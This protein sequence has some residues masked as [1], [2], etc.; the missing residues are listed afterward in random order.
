MDVAD[1]QKRGPV[2]HCLH[3]RLHQHDV[4]HRGFVNH[5]QITVERV[6]VAAFIAPT[7]GVDLQQ[8]VDRLG[9]QAGRL[10]HAFG[11]AACRRAQ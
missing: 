9:L 6:V 7:F 11:S 3:E 8:P 4:D 2:R 1:D 5:Q 10:S